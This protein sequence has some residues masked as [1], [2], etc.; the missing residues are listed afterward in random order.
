MNDLKQL[1]AMTA[2]NDMLGKSS[3]SICTIDNVAKLLDVN[4]RGEA[5]D[6]LRAVHCIE[7]ADMPPQLRDAIPDLIRQCLGVET[8]YRFQ[9][10][11]HKQI[12]DVTPPSNRGG[13]LRLIGLS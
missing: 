13:F 6:T 1:A 7:Y 10:P 3:F 11:L 5:Y 2:L 9:T 12:V 4:P 8:I